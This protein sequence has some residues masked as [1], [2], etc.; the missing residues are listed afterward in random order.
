MV[1]RIPLFEI[2]WD[3]AD[4]GNAAESISRGSYWAEGPFIDRF[5]SGL[6]DY[7]DVEHAVTVN[8]GTTALVA[9]LRA[10]NI[11]PGDEVIVPSFTFIATANA[12]RLVGAK[13]VFGDI[14]R[15]SYG[16][17]PESVEKELTDRTEAIVPVHLYGE[18]CRIEELVEIARS[19]G[20]MIIEDAAEAFGATFEG[21]YVGTFGEMGV[22]SFCQNKI[23]ATGEGGAVVTDDDELAS[24]LRMYRSHGRVSNDYF[25]SA[26]SGEYLTLGTNIRMSDLTAAVGCSQ[27]EK[28]DRLIEGRRRAATELNER[29]GA[30][31]G[32]SV[33]HPREGT[34]HV[35]QLYTVEFDPGIDR[36]TVI[37]TLESHGV[38]SK[39][40]WDT[41]IHET[42]FYQDEAVDEYADLPSTTTSADRVLSLPMHPDLGTTQIDHIVEA[43]KNGVEKAN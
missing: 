22:H 27:L 12:V 1:D 17:D 29:L 37:E 30:I 23:V 43:T 18:P 21:D 25:D 11:G 33:P 14:E 42:R 38:S 7:L 40:Y 20:L 6:A 8:S 9:S 41:P 13:P 4:V 2:A 16:L 5:E 10:A 32:V 15:D 3:G 34:T 31:D 36:R 28:V 19:E 26:E 35:Y 24:K 39:I